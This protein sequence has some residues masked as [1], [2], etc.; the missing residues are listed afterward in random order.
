[1]WLSNAVVTDV[2]GSNRPGCWVEVVPTGRFREAHDGAPAA[3]PVIDAGGI[4]V[5]PTPHHAVAEALLD[6]IVNGDRDAADGLYAD[7]LLVWHNHDGIERDKAESLEL[8]SA[9]ARE[10]VSMKA[11][12]VRRDHLADGYVQRT[13]F[14]IVGATGADELIDTMMRVWVQDARI[15]RIEEYALGDAAHIGS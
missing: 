11:T 10:L 9:M 15:T 8:I 4:E 13:T 3:G 7:E 5:D 2:D 12:V 6:A 1:V 14:H